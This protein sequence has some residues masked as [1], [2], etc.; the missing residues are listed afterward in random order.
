M[1]I[2]WNAGIAPAQ[3]SMVQIGTLSGGMGDLK[4]MY[5]ITKKLSRE[6]SIMHR[7]TL[8]LQA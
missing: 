4:M 6:N 2:R 7:I 3:E 5:G 1:E 8:M